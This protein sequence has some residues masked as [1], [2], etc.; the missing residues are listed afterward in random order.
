MCFLFIVTL[1]ISL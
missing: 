1:P